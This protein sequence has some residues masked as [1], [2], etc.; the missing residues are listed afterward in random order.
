M[1]KQSEDQSQQVK[2]RHF[3]DRKQKLTTDLYTFMAQKQ[4]GEW[5]FDHQKIK[6]FDSS[7]GFFRDGAG[8]MHVYFFRVY[9]NGLRGIDWFL[10]ERGQRYSGEDREMLERWREMKVSCYQ[11]VDQYEQGGVIEDIWSKERYRMPY[12]ETMPKL[13]PWTVSVGMLEPYFDDW[14]IHGVFMWGSPDVAAEVMSRVERLQEEQAQ[15]SGQKLSPS[16]ILARSYP[17]ILVLCDRINKSPKNPVSNL[18]DMR[19]KI[20]VTREYTCKSPELLE[21]MLLGLGNEY[22]LMPAA[23][24]EEGTTVINRINTQDGILDSLPADRR[25]QLCLDEIH[26]L[27]SLVN[28]EIGRQ[29]VTVTGWHSEELEAVLTLL[30]SEWSEAAGLTQV[31]EEREASHFPMGI[32]PKEYNILTDK[33]LSGQELKAYESLPGMLQWYHDTREKHP[34]EAAEIFVKRRE[35]EQYRMNPELYKLKLLR[36]ALG[37]LKSPFTG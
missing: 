6:P 16:D 33:K 7:L 29:R 1:R 5:T 8:D 21:K 37:L 30:E 17:E 22:I 36:V 31:H 3:F 32:M 12:S 25:E 10:Q 11:L 2:A 20:Y 24:P 23:N 15:A 13:P 34:E 26:I 27:D 18:A 19:E 28:F 9:D 35:Y 14:C 4:G